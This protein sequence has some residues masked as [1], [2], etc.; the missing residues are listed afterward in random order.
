MRK[1]MPYDGN[2]GHTGLV[3]HK[4]TFWEA[5]MM[6]VG[7]TIGSAVLG[8]AYATRKAGWPVLFIW[9]IVSA[10]LSTASM[11]Y[12]A[13]TALRTEKPLQ[14]SGL[15]QKYIGSKGSWLLFFAVGATSFCSLIAYT[16]GCG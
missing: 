11:L 13:E 7:S 6:V 14:L 3:V 4:L 1:N 9:L 10:L 2:G 5:A 8:L 16:N 15:A 12:V